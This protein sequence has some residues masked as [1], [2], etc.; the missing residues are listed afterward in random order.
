[1]TGHETSLGSRRRSCLSVLVAGQGRGVGSVGGFSAQLQDPNSGDFKK[2]AAVAQ[3]FVE[4]AQ[5]EPA[6]GRVGTNFRVS[7]PRLYAD[8]NRERAKAFRS[9]PSSACASA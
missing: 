2:F 1:M 6:I 4:R 5:K 9:S 7:S 8:V 3:Q